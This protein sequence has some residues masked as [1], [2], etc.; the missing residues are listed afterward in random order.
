[1]RLDICSKIRHCLMLCFYQRLPLSLKTCR[2]FLSRVSRPVAQCAV[3]NAFG[4]WFPCVSC[5]SSARLLWRQPALGWRPQLPCP[6]TG[7]HLNQLGMMMA[8]TN[9]MYA[10]NSEQNGEEGRVSG[11]KGRRSRRR[12]GSKKG[13][14]SF[15]QSWVGCLGS[16]FLANI[17]F[18][19]LTYQLLSDW[20][21]LVPSCLYGE[22]WRFASSV[23]CLPATALAQRRVWM[24]L[25]RETQRRIVADNRHGI[26]L[27]MFDS[28]TALWEVMKQ[29]LWVWE[30]S[31]KWQWSK[32]FKLLSQA[33]L[34]W[35][36]RRSSYYMN[37]CALARPACER[38]AGSGGPAEP[39][40]A[41]SGRDH[42]PCFAQCLEFTMLKWKVWQAKSGSTLGWA[43]V[44]QVQWW[45]IPQKLRPRCAKL[46]AECLWFIASYDSLSWVVAPKSSKPLVS[47][48]GW[49]GCAGLACC[50]GLLSAARDRGIRCRAV[51][52]WAGRAACHAGQEA[53]F[54]MLFFLGTCCSSR[55]DSLW[56]GSAC[57]AVAGAVTEL[58]EAAPNAC[59]CKKGVAFRVKCRMLP[60]SVVHPQEFWRSRIGEQEALFGE[61]RE[62]NMAARSMIPCAKCA[63]LAMFEVAV[64]LTQVASYQVWVVT[65]VLL[66]FHWPCS[67]SV[68]TY[69]LWKKQKVFA[70]HLSHWEVGHK[71]EQVSDFACTSCTS[72]RIKCC[73]DWHGL[74]FFQS[75]VAKCL[76]KGLELARWNRPYSCA[77]HW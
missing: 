71:A 5:P 10:S 25:L 38:V 45:P 18:V 26:E 53:S 56:R 27:G 40:I 43:S 75:H 46:L 3:G 19:T 7:W 55:A 37:S 2:R 60:C 54:T 13:A 4:C 30:I 35:R 14:T 63:G 23:W 61:A 52:R 31:F 32:S 49:A 36:A 66:P 15:V 11:S 12:T 67:T 29:H 73:P 33:G 34:A 22:P 68:L 58:A 57:K 72:A 50:L 1:M 76:A 24:Q 74:H 6:W 44:S 62:T 59:A 39:R 9:Y 69:Y 48:C 21:R 17:Y 70:V 8:Q 42:V 77:M 41:S 51:G 28:S 47:V 20:A 16:R 64:D 65:F